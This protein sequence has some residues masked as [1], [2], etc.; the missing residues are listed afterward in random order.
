MNENNCDIIDATDRYVIPGGIDPHTHMQMP[1]M[2]TVAIDDFF[3]GT[4]AALAGGTTMVLSR[5]KLSKNKFGD[6]FE[7]VIAIMHN[8]YKISFHYKINGKH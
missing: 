5:N 7:T 4:R 1:F 3:H 8:I 6:T 2:G